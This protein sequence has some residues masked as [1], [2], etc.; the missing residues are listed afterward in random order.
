MSTE[1]LEK[2]IEKL[3][4]EKEALK[5]ALEEKEREIDKIR[6][7]FDSLKKEFEEY[8][9]RHPETV[10]VKH[11]KPYIIKTSNS[12]PNPKKPGARIGHKPHNRQMPQYIDEIRPVPV[13]VC[14]NCHGTDLSE[15]VQETRT[16][17]FE[18]IPPCKPRVIQLSI[19]RRYCRTCKQLV[20][21]PVDEVLP[22]AR[23]S[24]RVMLIVTWL[25]IALR[26]TE[27]AIP[28]LL[29]SLFGLKIC[30]GEV[31]G[32]LTRVAEA[33]G[34][35]YDKL[36]ED[37]RNAPTRYTDETAW[38][39]N[40]DNVWLWAFVTNGETLY[41]I[42][43]SR[44]HKVPLEVVG[45]DAKGVDV[46]DGLSVYNTLARITK[47][48]QQR[49]WEHILADAK[50]LAERYGDEGQHILNILK[51]TYA[52]ASEFNHKGTDDDI[53]R[54]YEDMKQQLLASPYTSHR[55]WKFVENLL[56]LKD[57]LFVFVKNPDVDGTNNRAERALRP[58]V[59]ARKISGGSRSDRG[60]KIYEILMSVWRTL[61]LR[62]HDLIT[63]G[64]SIMLTSHG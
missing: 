16:H 9:M 21:K 40:G 61:T 24:L 42:A 55:C 50:E 45:K 17:T 13:D 36:I 43:Y 5:E 11:G 41:K 12:S 15:K 52:R 26:M 44:S 3:R 6:K 51:T 19:E 53:N 62:G 54:L 25:K 29:R 58:P 22:K 28:K 30:E 47:R 20:E 34:P 31:V 18:D 14:P 57:C 64:R 27:E 63:H 37:I 49:G 32:I 4:K 33:F 2:E 48:L 1:E 8:K 10:G 39:I 38:R 23:L 35:F 60:A 7:A 46:H 59:V 56:K